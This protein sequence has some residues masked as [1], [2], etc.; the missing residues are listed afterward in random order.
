MVFSALSDGLGNNL[1]FALNLINFNH[2][3]VKYISK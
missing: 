3:T 2:V 1:N